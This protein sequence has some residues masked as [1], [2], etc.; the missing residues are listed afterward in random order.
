MSVNIPL[1]SGSSYSSDAV[2][3]DGDHG[4][5]TSGT[6]VYFDTT[7][8][9][10]SKSYISESQEVKEKWIKA[11]NTFDQLIWP[12]AKSYM[13]LIENA[14]NDPSLNLS[15]HCKESAS[16]L[17]DGLSSRKHWALKFLDSTGRGRSGMAYGYVADVGNLDECITIDE[18]F[19]SNKRIS[20]K[21]CMLSLDLPKVSKQSIHPLFGVNFS[22][23]NTPLED[24]VYE[25][26]AIF[27]EQMVYTPVA[28]KFG[29]C[30]PAD[31]DEKQ[32][33][34]FLNNQLNNTHLTVQFAEH[35]EVLDQ[36]I[37]T[38]HLISLILVTSYILFV[39]LASYISWNNETP[40]GIF[41]HF[42]FA[43]HTSKLFE[44][45]TDPTAKKLAFFHGIRFFYQ[46]VAIIFHTID[47]YPFLPT[48][49]APMYIREWPMWLI[50]QAYK[51][52]GFF[53]Q[54]PFAVS[55]FLTYVTLLPYFRLKKG[56]VSFLDFIFK[57]WYR[58]TP[59]IVGVMIFGFAWAVFGR[60]PVFRHA[61]ELTIETCKNYWWAN[62]LYI[63][64]WFKYE[65]MC[66]FHT[67]TYSAD[68]QLY[69]ISF[70]VFKLAVVKPSRALKMM[71]FF[72]I[73]GSSISGFVTWAKELNAYPNFTAIDAREYEVANL[74]YF[75]TYNVMPAYFIG[76]V[77]AYCFMENKKID[78]SYVSFGWTLAV[79]MGLSVYFVPHYV[80]FDGRSTRWLEILFASVH[81]VLFTIPFVWSGYLSAF[82]LGGFVQWLY[83]I[84]LWIPFGRM[85]SS[86][87]LAHFTFI[88]FDLANSMDYVSTR[89][90]NLT[91]RSIYIVVCSWIYS[92]LIYLLFEA[93][94][95]SIA[96]AYLLPSS[97]KQKNSLSPTGSE[98]DKKST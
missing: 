10:S 35:C 73:L 95:M 44:E 89:G 87:F 74:M 96:K 18:I 7:L 34:K 86:V 61:Q 22:L 15:S 17:W 64:N 19:P 30:L 51:T 75:Y 52:I 2:S 94:S 41:D 49:Y 42:N 63:N 91:M 92:Y 38:H 50:G 79:V 25:L 55:G 68:F 98:K 46:L 59:M 4:T 80:E 58:T 23:Q 13:Q 47:I 78:E 20:G 62:L 5:T 83:E 11:S 16:L 33:E 37:A 9:P 3:D 97:Q 90:W 77:A 43:R 14:M 88:W 21:Y 69:A 8:D 12:H 70:I 45:T 29:I 1:A 36:P 60:G 54:V 28:F 48:V 81:R 66:L 24:T 26:Y 93:P 32:A 72:I 85:S 67:W 39:L 82:S 53:V 65:N 31:C 76:M 6:R 40:Q 56:K 27:M 57:R 84:K 71:I